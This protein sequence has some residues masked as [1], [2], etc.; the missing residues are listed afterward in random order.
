M[1]SA[2]RQTVPA[3]LLLLLAL[4]GCP[5]APKGLVREG[6]ELLAAKQYAAAAKVFQEALNSPATKG[7]DRRRAA[8]G[9]AKAF[10][11]RGD[12]TGAE[13]RLRRLE[14]SVSDKWYHLAEVALGRN[15]P[16]RARACFQRALDLTHGGDTAAR[17]AALLAAEARTPREL[18]GA[19]G[20]FARGGQAKDAAAVR[21]AAEVWRSM[22]AERAAPGALLETLTQQATG[23]V[24]ELPAVRVLRAQLL[25]RAGRQAEADKAWALGKGAS[26]EY[27]SHVIE[28]RAR[29]AIRRGDAKAL[30]ALLTKADLHTAARVRRGLAASL[31][32]RGDLEAAL[33]LYADTAQ[34][35]GRPAALA[36]AE[37][38]RLLG[39]LGR[40]EEA[41]RAWTRAA[42]A[43]GERGPELRLLLARRR[44]LQ[45]DLLGGCDLLGKLEG[46]EAGSRAEAAAL[47][48]AGALL[49]AGLAAYAR[50]QIRAVRAAARSVRQLVPDEPASHQLLSK[51]RGKPSD[52][53]QGKTRLAL[54]RALLTRALRTG[55]LERADPLLRGP[56]AKSLRATLNRE[57]HVAVREALRRQHA[58]AAGRFLE[59]HRAL[60]D[61]RRLR[62]CAC[63][64]TFSGAVLPEP[65]GVRAVGKQREWGSLTAPETGMRLPRVGLARRGK[66]WELRFPAGGTVRFASDAELARVLGARSVKLLRWTAHPDQDDAAIAARAE[67]ARAGHARKR[68]PL[69]LE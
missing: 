55:D 61:L 44:T 36:A 54:L 63:C 56:E 48:R 10:L 14:D 51:L 34:A 18:L 15:D 23:A 13:T 49:E 46:L 24:A 6:E 47:V 11:Y 40:R 30:Q 52:A 28:L 7:L 3:L 19:A 64:S 59:A 53:V 20:V 62:A 21:K 38:A 26:P 33:A 1:T 43:A 8:V 60:L 27:R 17:L 29:L 45:G 22:L 50:G 12:L 2:A 58:K 39:L 57:M 42:K 66:G 68:P 37:M 4:A 9:E 5:S 35:G 69:E 31:R 32:W 67:Q 41:E 65:R 16:A 25:E